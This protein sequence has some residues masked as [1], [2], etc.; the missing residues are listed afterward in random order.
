[1]K[2]IL[3]YQYNYKCLKI[4]ESD[5]DDSD[6]AKEPVA[7]KPKTNSQLTGIVST[8]PVSENAPNNLV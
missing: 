8:L 6:E 5:G 2:H 3:K 7:K 1:M 4:A